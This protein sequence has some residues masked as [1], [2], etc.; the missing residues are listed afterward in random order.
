M[1]DPSRTPVVGAAILLDGAV[2]AA[3]RTAPAELAGR[4]EFPGG[5]VEPDESPEEALVRE[6]AEELGC[7]IELTGWLPG[8]APIGDTHEL[9]VACGVLIEGEPVP[10]EHDQVRWVTA[11]E[12]D[13]VD[14]LDPDRPF[15]PA[16]REFLR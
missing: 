2:L 7:R 4:W 13:E 8:S 11:D 16:L 3:R 9:R 6:I 5:K 1:T 15:L 14:W 10:T 12:L